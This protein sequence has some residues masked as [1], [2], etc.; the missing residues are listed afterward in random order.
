[1]RI[2]CLSD[3]HFVSK[4]GYTSLPKRRHNLALELL[5]RVIERERGNYEVIIL[6]GDLIDDGKID[7]SEKDFFEIKKVIEREKKP[8]IFVMGNHDIGSDKISEIFKNTA[9]LHYREYIFYPFND[10]YKD[11]DRCYREKEEIE[12]F[13]NFCRN[14]RD[15]KIITVQ[16]NVVY[17]KIE[18]DYPYNIENSEKILEIYRKCNVILSIS[19]HY[20][21][22]VEETEY[23]GIYFITLPALCESPFSYYIIEL[24]G[25]INFIKK[26]LYINKDF[27]LIDFHCHTEFAYCRENV[28]CEKNIERAKIF[29][30]DGI[31]LTEHSSH[32]YLKPEETR[33]FIDGIDILYKARKENRDRMSE[34][35]KRVFPL[36][37]EYVKVGMEVECDKNGNIT[38]L[39]ED[40]E[41]IDYLVGAVHFLP[42]E[43]M[44]SKK[45]VIEGFL[46]FTEFLCK[47]KID[48]IAHPFRFFL[49]NKMDVPKDIYDDVVRIL[50]EYNVAAELNFHSG[51]RPDPLFFE[52]CINGGVKIS[53]ASDAHNLI[54]VG[55]FSKHIDFLRKID[56]NIGEFLYTGWL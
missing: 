6:C 15:K 28:E 23:N 20:H 1:M 11:D 47:N 42:E 33:L 48:I 51:N 38:L 29:G 56:P 19:G 8:Y 36:K 25:K 46:K 49:R 2:L 26:S 17:P 35:K 43:Y 5:E 4:E 37:G 9:P 39:P 40:M 32:L 18:S 7:T 3:L 24:D 41:G 44:V 16:H 14:N 30:L 31:V 27:P 50:K 52:K 21:K 53:L 10:E 55:E 45:K 12:K 34:F 13:I 54:E 22:G